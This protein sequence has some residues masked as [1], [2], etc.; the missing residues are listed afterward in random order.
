MLNKDDTG[1]GILSIKEWMKKVR[2][3]DG[4]TRK[5]EAAPLMKQVWNQQQFA[6]KYVGKKH[7]TGK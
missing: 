5:Y 6:W 7:G 4:E 3:D 2:E 1:G